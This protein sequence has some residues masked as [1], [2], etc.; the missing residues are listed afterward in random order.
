M[1]FTET[2]QTSIDSEL[3]E[4][5]PSEQFAGLL[6]GSSPACDPPENPLQLYSNA[7]PADELYPLSHFKRS[8]LSQKQLQRQSNTDLVNKKKPPI[9]NRTIFLSKSNLGETNTLAGI[10]TRTGNQWV[11]NTAGFVERACTLGRIR[12]L[13]KTLLDMHLSKYVSKSDSNL[14]SYPPNEQKARRNWTES[15]AASENS[16]ANSERT[17]SFTSEWEEVSSYLSYYIH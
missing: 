6:H 2:Q 1:Y 7:S 3:L 11:M 5:H 9:L 14:I 10:T 13:P 4:V 16:R 12:T 15:V 17:P 8:I